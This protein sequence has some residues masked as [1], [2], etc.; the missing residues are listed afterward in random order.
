MISRDRA[1]RIARA[2]DPAGLAR[3]A[4]RAAGSAQDGGAA[5]DAAVGL[6]LEAGELVV[7]TCAEDEDPPPLPDTTILLATCSAAEREYHTRRLSEGRRIPP[8]EDIIEEEMSR[9][10]GAG[11]SWTKL[12]QILDAAYGTEEGQR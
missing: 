4:W 11:T 6:D 12:E 2:L 1:R 8:S 9:V 10:A 3:R 7:L 5:L